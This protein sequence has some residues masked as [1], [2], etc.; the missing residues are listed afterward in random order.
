MR[1]TGFIQFILL[2]FRLRGR[3]AGSSRHRMR[4]IVAVVR[5]IRASVFLMFVS[6]GVG[7]LGYVII[8]GYPWFDAYYMAVITLASVGFGEVH[9]LGVGG[10]LFTSFLILFNIGLF[11]YAISSITSVFAEGGF[12]KL[13]NDFRMHGTIERLSGHTIVCGFG[14]HA[15]EVAQELS[16]QRM[17][18][19]VIEKKSD[20]IEYLRVHTNYLYVEGDATQDE[21]LEEAGI[22]RAASLVTTLPDDADNLF[23][24]LSARQIGPT[25]RIIS[26][27]NNEAD[28]IKLRRAGASQTVVPER[29][30][31]FYMATL[32]NKP[33]LV[34]FFTLLS[35]M[36][37]S[38]VVFEEVVVGELLPQFRG[39]TIEQCGLFK[40]TR[41]ALVAIRYPN[42][43]YELNPPPATM[44]LPDWHIVVLGNPDQVAEFRGSAIKGGG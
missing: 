27:A 28:E 43:Q 8:E 20:K 25:L 9:P 44:L 17:P 4:R 13:L 38:N 11:A 30:G 40:Q 35:N 23:V 34:E 26:R 3:S 29:I 19:V 2:F 14:R 32:V 22:R 24:T 1:S 33:D 36:G 5:R 39:K 37:P 42:G 21:I 18:F 31:G 10:R 41:V 7:T 15:T 6:L 16:K 12:T